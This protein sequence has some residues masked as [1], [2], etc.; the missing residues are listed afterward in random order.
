MMRKQLGLFSLLFVMLNSVPAQSTPLGDIVENF[1][2]RFIQ[3]VYSQLAQ[4]AAMLEHSVVEH[5]SAPVQEKLE[6]VRNTFGNTAIAWAW[7]ESV[8]FGPV[9]EKNRF[10]RILFWPDP[11]AI[12][13]RQVARLLR[14]S[15]NGKPDDTVL[16][17]A[18]LTRKSVALQGLGTL[19]YLLYSGAGDRLQA[20]HPQHAYNCKYALA[21]AA[22]LAA[23]TRDIADEWQDKSPNSHAS[24]LTHPGELNPLY[25]NEKE[26]LVQVYKILDQGLQVVADLKLKKTLRNSL[27]KSRPK[28]AP[29]WRSDLSLP[30]L[31]AHL[32]A[33]RSYFVASG[34]D[35]LLEG[36]ESGMRASLLFDFTTAINTAKGI[37]LPI[38]QAMKDAE[39]YQK[40]KFLHVTVANLRASLSRQVTEAAGLPLSF[41][42]LDGD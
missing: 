34:L 36:N 6:I 12:G 38:T 28:R 31:A 16:T 26:A 15:T 8:R 11:K 40:L 17:L 22:N 2:V 27:V 18:S 1:I 42:N 25:R 30:S 21:I 24:L 39:S 14:K 4:Q 33:L 19:E 7:A 23:I 32:E 5:C 37:K 3:P 10:E 41:N 20:G 35:T 13:I 29:F 9:T